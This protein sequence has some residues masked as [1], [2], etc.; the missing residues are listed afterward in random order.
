MIR[1]IIWFLL[2]VPCMDKRCQKISS[3]NLDYCLMIC[4]NEVANDSDALNICV[5]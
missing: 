5:S 2:A 4:V 3:F 1:L